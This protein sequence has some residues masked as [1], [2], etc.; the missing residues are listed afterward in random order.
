MKNALLILLFAMSL[1]SAKAQRLANFDSLRREKATL[2]KSPAT[3]QNQQKLV[4]LLA[5]FYDIYSPDYQ[6]DTAQR[7]ITQALAISRKIGWKK[8]EALALIRL[9]SNKNVSQHYFEAYQH[10]RQALG[11]AQTAGNDSLT[12]LALKALA[13]NY[14]T[15]GQVT[16][17]VEYTQKAIVALRRAQDHNLVSICYKNLGYMRLQQG[18]STA[19]LNA[20]QQALTYA[21]QHQAVAA[22]AGAY[23]NLGE[24]WLEHGNPTLGISYVER[25]RATF[26]RLKMP[27]FA[28]EADWTMGHHYLST[29]QYQSAIY[30]LERSYK[31]HKQLIHSNLTDVLTPLYEAHKALEQNDRALFYLEQKMSLLQK[32][33]TD[34]ANEITASNEIQ[35]KNEQQKTELNELRIKELSNERLFL[36]VG[37]LLLALLGVLLFW[38]NRKLRTKNQELQAKNHQISEALL[39]GQ[40]T[41]RRRVAAELHDN[42][43]GLLAALKLTINA[44]DTSDLHPQE[45]EIYG[46]MVG[47]IN[48]A[49]RQVRS[50]SHNLL[51]EELAEIGLV[52]SL[53]KLVSKLNISHQ[54]QFDLRI[55]G[56]A[57]PLDKQTE[58][59]LY[60]IVLELCNNILKHANASEA[61]VE[62]MEKNDILQL[63]VSDDGTGFE[64]NNSTK[65]GM[66]LRNLYER[67][68]AV[69][70]VVRVHS[71]KGE[72]TVVS[73][74]IGQVSKVEV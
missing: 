44:L 51:P 57:K 61:T 20:Y 39:K 48:D 2:E 42:L 6:R 70:G 46:Q 55:M 40:T 23:E 19:A 73:L 63:L 14:Y 62:L 4:L 69:G 33:Q 41:E 8:G 66:G 72:G 47:M 24:Y 1:F 67:A 5:N 71:Q 58:F 28:A 9:G 60:A 10:F 43:G 74:K 37:A 59:N 68:E 65:E 18:D 27:V 53:E 32:N 22:E 35:L 34:R 3:P 36:L 12:G 64:A 30:Y 31:I 25:A 21:Q 15:R 16:L 7:Y 29:K 17:G 13:G 49:N 56:L 45:Q 54:T 26:E 50:L 11:L 52:A 38:Y